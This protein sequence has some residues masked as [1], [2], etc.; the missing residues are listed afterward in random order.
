MMKEGRAMGSGNRK[1]DGCEKR[2]E[3]LGLEA[4]CRWVNMHTFLDL[5]VPGTSPILRHKACS[6]EKMIQGVDLGAIWKQIL[7]KNKTQSKDVRVRE[8]S[9]FLTPSLSF[10]HS[11]PLML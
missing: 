9:L 10:P 8:L 5:A 7:Q 3:G 2:K 6:S 11:L 1:Q 4:Q